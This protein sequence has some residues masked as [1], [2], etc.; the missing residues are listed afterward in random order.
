MNPSG[1]SPYAVAAVLFAVAVLVCFLILGVVY[2]F[3]LVGN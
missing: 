3:D 1:P 2:H